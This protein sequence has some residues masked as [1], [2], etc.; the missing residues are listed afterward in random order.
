M[1]LWWGF[2]GVLIGGKGVFDSIKK[3]YYFLL[4]VFRGTTAI[5]QPYFSHTLSILYPTLSILLIRL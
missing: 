1:G 3:D 2:D 5:L 4:E